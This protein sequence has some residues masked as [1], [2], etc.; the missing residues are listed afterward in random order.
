M[1]PQPSPQHVTDLVLGRLGRFFG[2]A[3]ASLQVLCCCEDTGSSVRLREPL[4]ALLQLA[5][6]LCGAALE[7]LMVAL[8]AQLCDA[9]ASL[10]PLAPA[11]SFHPQPPLVSVRLPVPPLPREG[12][13]AAE[14]EAYKVSAPLLLDLLAPVYMMA[15]VRC[16]ATQ[17]TADLCF[18]HTGIPLRFEYIFGTG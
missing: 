12:E 13:A 18:F 3:G 7:P 4:A 14:C 6:A 2:S 16:A 17:R 15:L 10:V 5:R 9:P 11:A 8:V 1:G